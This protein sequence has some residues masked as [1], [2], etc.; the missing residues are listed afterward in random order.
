MTTRHLM[1]SARVSNSITQLLEKYKPFLNEQIPSVSSVFGFIDADCKMYGGR[2]IGTPALTWEQI[3]E[4]NEIGVGFSVTL[5]NHFV[6]TE[7]VNQGIDLLAKLSEMSSLN[8][9][10][11]LNRRFAKM[12]KAV[13]PSILLKQSA[14]ANPRTLDSIS[15]AL[16][17][18]DLVTISHTMLDETEFLCSLPPDIK[19]RLVMFATGGCAYRCEAL[20]CYTGYSQQHAL[21]PETS[22]CTGLNRANRHRPDYFRWELSNPIFDGVR[23]IKLVEPPPPPQF[24]QIKVIAPISRR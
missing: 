10:V 18:Y 1:A 21:L 17:V 8:S 12:V 5:T 22:E 14:I 24:S 6:S 3:K 4:L 13:Y 15:R 11:I 19:T 2:T 20:T 7:S 16:D 9:A 23:Y